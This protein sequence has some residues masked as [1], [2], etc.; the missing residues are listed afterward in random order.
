M[1]AIGSVLVLTLLLQGSIAQ[2]VLWSRL[3]LPANSRGCLPQ[4]A[5]VDQAG[6]LVLAARYIMD[7]G[8]FAVVVLKYSPQGDLLW[9]AHH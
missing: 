3:Y 1:R 2:S 7:A 4:V 5:T 9:A 8:H 6:N